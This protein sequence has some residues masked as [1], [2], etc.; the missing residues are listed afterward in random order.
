M[1]RIAG[2]E[3]AC[4]TAL[5]NT[6]DESFDENGIPCINPGHDISTPHRNRTGKPGDRSDG[7]LRPAI[8]TWGAHLQVVRRYRQAVYL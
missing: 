5:R 6:I 2:I 3:A 4:L 7:W 8:S 1:G